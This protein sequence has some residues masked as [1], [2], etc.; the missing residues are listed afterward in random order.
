M[1]TIALFLGTLLC[2]SRAP[3]E[4]RRGPGVLTALYEI[5]LCRV[6]GKAYWYIGF[7]I[8]GCRKMAYKRD[9]RPYELLGPDGKWHEPDDLDSTGAA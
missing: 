8:D 2:V 3:A 4:Q 7:H 5:E 1:K 9:Y 6:W